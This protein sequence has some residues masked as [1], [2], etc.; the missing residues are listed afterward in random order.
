V[1]EKRRLLHI[2]VGGIEVAGELH[3]FLEIGRP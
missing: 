2:V 3:D 1:E